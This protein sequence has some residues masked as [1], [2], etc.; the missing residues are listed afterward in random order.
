M[1]DL[2]IWGGT[3]NFKVLCELLWE[4]YRILG[5]FDRDTRIQRSYRGIPYLGNKEAFVKW[6]EQLSPAERPCFFISIGA[7]HGL[8]RQKLHDELKT[9]GCKPIKAIHKTAFVAPSASLEEGTAVFAQAAVCVDAR[10]G[11]NCIINTRASIDH[12]CSVEEGS[13]IGP[14][15]TLAGLVQVGP[16]VDIYSAAVILPRVK[17]GTGAVVGAG[18]V[19]LGDVP[20]NAVVVG[21]PA[22]MIRKT[23]DTTSK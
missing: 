17:I 21:N 13:T 12:E 10:I 5:F 19:V 6:I 9:Y 16:N 2:I 22:R 1:Q 15:A 11:K 4:D 20:P 14:G 18:A 7:G 8:T 23:T 3:G